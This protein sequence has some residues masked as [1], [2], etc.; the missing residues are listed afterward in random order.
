MNI[1]LHFKSQ[2]ARKK[3]E[4]SKD[5]T[6]IVKGWQEIEVIEM[7]SQTPTIVS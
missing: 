2:A 6:M 7:D 3:V 1:I 4:I 5:S